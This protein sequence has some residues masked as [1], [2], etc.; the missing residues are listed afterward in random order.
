MW[1]SL[2]TFE[3]RILTSGSDR[4]VTGQHVYN[5]SGLGLG[6]VWRQFIECRLRASI[7]S[8][9]FGFSQ[10]LGHHTH[11]NKQQQ[12]ATNDIQ[13]HSTQKPTTFTQARAG[14]VNICMCIYI[15]TYIHTTI[16][17]YI[18]IYEY[19]YTPICISLSLSIYIYIY[20]YN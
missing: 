11:N 16:Y 20:I 10:K 8:F 4:F 9:D 19:T 7:F 18:Y 5:F 14:Y 15:Y 3:E 2:N 17:I 13:T 6:V 12:S 1:Q